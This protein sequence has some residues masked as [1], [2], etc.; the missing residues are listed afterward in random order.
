MSDDEI[1]EIFYLVIEYGGEWDEPSQSGYGVSQ[2]KG[3]SC[4]ALTVPVNISFMELL[5][6]IAT[7]IDDEHG[8]DN[9]VLVRRELDDLTKDYTSEE[10]FEIK[11][12][13][14]D[15]V[16]EEV[17]RWTREELMRQFDNNEFEYLTKDSFFDNVDA[18]EDYH[19][20]HTSQ[21][22]DDVPI[23][24]HIE[25]HEA[26][27]GFTKGCRPI[28][29]LDG[30]FLKGQYGGQCLSI[31]S[32]DAN[33]G[34]FPIAV[35]IYRN[36]RV[37]LRQFYKCSLIPIIDFVLGT[38]TKTSSNCTEGEHVTNNFSKSF[39]NWIVKI[40]DKPLNKMAERLN[41]MQMTLMYER[42]LKAKEWD[43]NGLVL[44]TVKRIELLK[45]YSH[46]YKLEG[47]EKDQWLVLNDSS[48][49]HY[50]RVTTYVA[51]YNQAVN[52]IAD[53]SDWGEPTR[54]IR[55]PPLLRPAGRPRT[56]RKRESNEVNGMV[57]QPRRCSKCQ[58]FG[59]NNRTYKGQPAEKP[60]M[61]RGGAKAYRL[62]NEFM[63]PS[64]R[65]KGRGKAEEPPQP[66]QPSIS[67]STQPSQQSSQQSQ[68]SQSFQP[69]HSTGQHFREPRQDPNAKGE[70]GGYRT[71][72]TSR[73]LTHW[74]GTSGQ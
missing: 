22:G 19:S 1:Y 64:T 40:R 12:E 68:P 30:C 48:T 59:H 53:S 23:M 73:G 8:P 49:S 66:P 6:L 37:L 45:T 34:I 62:D 44:R 60:R 4:F 35:F 7:R 63:T 41:L 52:P 9:N 27:D 46:Y 57:R 36:K 26:L 71:T 10:E 28:F 61:G 70:H 39:N 11:K 31:I 33:N 3:G 50:H 67:I 2:Y 25:D 51:T 69:S 15:N 32:L 58:T 20:N 56:L 43:Q 5:G 54:D 72:Q 74:C 29:G 65:G 55:P 38:C 42:K 47:F 13:D 17:T 16:D 21:D 18:E 14:I 24:D